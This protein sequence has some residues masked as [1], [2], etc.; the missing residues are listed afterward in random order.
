M[1][2]KNL[3]EKI[4]K[5]VGVNCIDGT[6]ECPGIELAIECCFGHYGY[7]SYHLNLRHFEQS[8]DNSSLVLGFF[9]SELPATMQRRPSFLHAVKKST[10]CLVGFP[11]HE[12][13]HAFM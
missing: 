12:N 2:R 5:P 8:N 1:Q 3:F 7:Q 9:E 11:M 4:I 6:I 13:Q 10:T